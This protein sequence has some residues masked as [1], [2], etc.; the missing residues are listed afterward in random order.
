MAP[1]KRSRH[2]FPPQARARRGRRQARKSPKIRR[3]CYN[4]TKTVPI[5]TTVTSRI[6]PAPYID[7]RTTGD[8]P[9][10]EGVDIMFWQKSAI[11]TMDCFAVMTGLLIAAPFLL[12]LVSPFLVTY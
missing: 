10:E 12:I 4:F 2:I 6:K 5:V 3:F 11:V 1:E 7:Y 8:G 9:H